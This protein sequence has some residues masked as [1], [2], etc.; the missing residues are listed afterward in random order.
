MKIKWLADAFSDA[1]VP[2]SSR[3]LSGLC[4]LTSCFTIIFIAVKTKLYPDPLTAGGLGAFST[5]H[6]TVNAFKSVFKKEQNQVNPIDP[7]EPVDPNNP[8]VAK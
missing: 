7:V 6:I 8:I 5:A 3:L 1:G 4:T 2:S